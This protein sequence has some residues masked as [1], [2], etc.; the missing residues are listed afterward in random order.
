MKHK[1]FIAI[2]FILAQMGVYGQRNPRETVTVGDDI[3][4]PYLFD[5]GEIVRKAG[6]SVVLP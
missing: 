6:S 4:L 5:D 1:R 3:F 2:L